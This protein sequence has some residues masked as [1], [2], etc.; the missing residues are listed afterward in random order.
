MDSAKLFEEISLEGFKVVSGNNF[1]KAD[2]PSMSIRISNISFSKA[3]YEAL[4]KCDNV[5]LMIHEQKKY[6]AVKPCN[7]NEKNAVKW[8][9]TANKDKLS[10]HPIQCASFGKQIFSMW[11]WDEKL[12]YRV[13][14]KLVM[15]DNKV[16]LMFDF[17][18]PDIYEGSKL[19]KNSG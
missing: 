18:C 8:I 17:S 10:H 19:V 7:S 9:G 16:L 5:V 15:S 2:E 11:E 13:T 1:G 3:T 4:N 6:I 14:G 12:R